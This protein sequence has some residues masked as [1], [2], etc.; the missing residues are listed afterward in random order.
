[1]VYKIWVDWAVSLGK[2]PMQTKGCNKADELLQGQQQLL[3]EGKLR[4]LTM[5]KARKTT[6]INSLVNGYDDDED[7]DDDSNNNNNNDDDDDMHYYCWV[8]LMIPVMICVTIA[9]SLWMI[10][11]ICVTI[12][13]SIYS[14]NQLQLQ[15]T[16]LRLSSSCAVVHIGHNMSSTIMNLWQHSWH[17][18]IQFQESRGPFWMYHTMCV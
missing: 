12:A 9:G 3:W 17:F 10:P 14:N 15:S 16:C 5:R 8:I 7:N 4:C 18:P 6:S 1:M 2:S 13:N 11:V